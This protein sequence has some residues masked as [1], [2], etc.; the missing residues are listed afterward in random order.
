MIGPPPAASNGQPR[1]DFKTESLG[2]QTIDGVQC[3]GRRVTTTY[4]TGSQGNDR[5]IVVTQET[6]MSPE[7]KTTVLTKTSDPRSG[8]MTFK[9]LNLSRTEPDA[10]LFQAPP[11]YQ[12][13][14]GTGPVTID[15]KR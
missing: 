11:D 2:A 7:L 6:W 3:E 4:P 13:V 1:P 15:F 10:S 8:E 12:V 9:I 5:P 14:D